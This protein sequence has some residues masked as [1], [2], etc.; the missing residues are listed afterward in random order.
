MSVSKQKQEPIGKENRMT[1]QAGKE[2]QDINLM[3][4]KAFRNRLKGNPEGRQ[5]IF[6]EVSAMT[7]HEQ[8]NMVMDTQARFAQIPARIRNK[9]GNDPWRLLKWLENPANAKEAVKQGLMVDQGGLFDEEE[10]EPQLNAVQTSITDPPPPEGS[11]DAFVAGT[12][13]P[14]ANPRKSGKKA[15]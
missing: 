10:A 12:A 8:L 14:E 9:H 5:P 2:S 15:S 6:G 13:D 4:K 1:E 7:Y 3:A 11:L